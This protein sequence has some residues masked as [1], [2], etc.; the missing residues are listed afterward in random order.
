MKG[1]DA[2]RRKAVSHVAKRTRAPAASVAAPRTDAIQGA[3]RKF[4]CACTTTKPRDP[5]VNNLLLRDESDA[6]IKGMYAGQRDKMTTRQVLG[7]LAETG[8]HPRWRKASRRR[9]AW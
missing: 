3:A 1:A 6:T 8:R 7:S 9:T 4:Q 5:C 2:Y